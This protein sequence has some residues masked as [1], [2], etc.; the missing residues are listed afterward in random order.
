MIFRL[1]VDSGSLA[2]PHIGEG[3]AK[4]A[5]SLDTIA[6]ACRPCAPSQLS[7]PLRRR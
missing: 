5:L 3:W 6:L 7:P 1:T 2:G 4:F